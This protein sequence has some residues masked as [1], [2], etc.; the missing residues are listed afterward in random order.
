MSVI[1][2]VLLSGGAGT[3]LWPLSRELSPKQLHPLLGTHSLLQDTALRFGD[4]SRFAA[5]LVICNEEHRF[6][7]AEQLRALSIKPSAIALEPAGRN[8]APAICLASLFVE[9]RHGG[10]A[11]LL[12]APADH[13]IREQA[14]FMAAIDTA[15]EAAGRGCI[16]TFGITPGRPETGYGYIRCGEALAGVAGAFHIAAFAEKPDFETARRYLAEGGYCWNSGMF[17]F[18]ARTML[19]AMERF[20]PDMLHA[21]RAALEEAGTDLDFLRLGRSFADARKIAIDVAIMERADNGAVVPADIGWSDVGAWD[22]LQEIGPHDAAGNT[23]IGDVLLQDVRNSYV[24]SEG[25]LTAVVGLDKAVVVVTRDAVLVTSLEKVQDVRGIVDELKRMGRSEAT[26]PA[27][28]PRPWGWYE[29][30]D[31]GNRFKVKHIEVSP[32]HSLSLQ[33]HYH[34]AEHWIVVHGVA[35]VTRG[36][37]RIILHENESIY[38]PTGTVHRLH[39]PGKVPLKLVEVQT[40]SYLGEDDIVR[41]SDGYGRS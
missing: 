41:F 37:E 29:T 13:L 14:R 2:P 11:L 33:K 25:M 36:E 34:R 17:L 1:H 3:R 15:C 30:I 26:L 12:V 5:P 39:N 27:R 6:A 16:V 24:R 23:C 18:A 21:C 35:E 32:G 7:I 38:I 4:V 22:A 28:A 31:E 9:Q 8:T 19:A 20:E 40:G 10:D